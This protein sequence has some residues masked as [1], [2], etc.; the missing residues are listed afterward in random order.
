MSYG[1][2]GNSEIGV[3]QS[4][5]QIQ[6]GGGNRNYIIGGRE[7]V[8]AANVRLPNSALS[9][10]TTRQFNAGVDLALFN[11]RLSVTFDY[12]TKNTQD[13]LAN[14]PLPG[15]TGFGGILAN[16]G[17]YQIQG[18]ELTLGGDVV[19]SSN[20][21]WTS[22][23]NVSYNQNEILD[24]PENRNPSFVGGSFFPNA[25]NRT[26]GGISRWEEG[27]AFGSFYG[28]VFDGLFQTQEEVD[29]LDQSAVGGSRLGGLKYRDLNNDGIITNDDDRQY[30]GSGIPD[31]I[32]GWNNTLSYKNWELNVLINGTTGNKVVNGINSLLL[33][34]SG[35]T[36][37]RAET[38]NYWQ[39]PNTSNTI[40]RPDASAPLPVFSTFFVEDG[41]FLR[42]RNIALGYTLPSGLLGQAVSQARIFA[43]ATNLL[44]FTNYSGFDPEVDANNNGVIPGV[45]SDSY[46]TNKTYRIGINITL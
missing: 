44:T 6:L 21:R 37:L 5:A 32:F 8:G 42:V 10:E 14:L 1:L 29:A 26:A 46:P 38:I 40:P 18:V 23:A 13:L 34:P 11:S 16:S 7:L 2:T 27:G 41:S 17:E 25:G 31:Y 45:D 35:E 39:G 36:N 20:F 4:L 19:R 9:W 12:Y 30:I 28:F 33:F 43:S 22:S 15:Y 3:Y 24:L